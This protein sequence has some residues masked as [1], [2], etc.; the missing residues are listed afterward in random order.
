MNILYII[1]IIRRVIDKYNFFEKKKPQTI[2][3]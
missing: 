1:R 3:K 2:F